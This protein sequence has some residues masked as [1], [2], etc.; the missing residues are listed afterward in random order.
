VKLYVIRGSHAC[1]TATLMFAHKALEYDEVRVPAATQ[2][3]VLALLRFP[4][5]TRRRLT[6]PALRDGEARIVGNRGIARH[7][8]AKQP[9]PPLLPADP[10]A[11]RAVEEAERFADEELQMVARRLV[12]ALVHQGRAAVDGAR[13]G[14]LG[15]LLY[16]DD[17]VRWVAAHG[18][19]RF[20]NVNPQT[21]ARLLG[22][23]PA[24]LDRIDGWIA[25][26]TLDGERLNVADL[27][28]APCLALLTYRPDLRPEVAR[29]PAGRL[30]SR[31][32]DR[33]AL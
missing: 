21:E 33:H 27:M 20:F 9:D 25:G 22:Q 11:R 16:A 17:R 31:V 10:Q 28:I 7:L 23:L 19:A 30:L 4:G 26:G 32:I 3:I 14:P 8:D 1:R 15:P 2:P 13:D 29:R 18:I 24:M 6:V 12:L 5:W